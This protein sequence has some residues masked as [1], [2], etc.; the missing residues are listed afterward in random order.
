MVLQKPN[1]TQTMAYYTKEQIEEKIKELNDSDNKSLGTC[2]K[3]SFWKNQLNNNLVNLKYEA[4][5]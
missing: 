5:A 4:N 2:L 3:L 1:K